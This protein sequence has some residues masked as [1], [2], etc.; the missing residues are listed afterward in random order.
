MFRSVS[1][2]IVI[3]VFTACSTSER[4]CSFNGFWEGPH[5]EDPNKKFYVQ[6]IDPDSSYAK[7]YWTDN[8][9][10]DS[11]F[12]IDSLMIVENSIH[13]FV[14]HWNCTYLGEGTESNIR[15]GFACE[16]EPFDSVMLVKNDG[17]ARYLTD[18]LPGCNEAG[19]KYHCQIP[20]QID[21]LLITSNVENNT[22]SLFI[23]SLLPEIINGECGRLNSFLLI[24]NNE[25]ICEEYFYGYTQNTLH[26]AESTT[27]S[28]TSI[29]VG[30]ALD[31]GFISGLNEPVAT[32]LEAPDFD[33]RIKMKHLLSMTSGLTPN[34]EKL[35]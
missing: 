12:Q 15:G 16:G 2:F 7:G 19:Y 24:K 29:L 13:F 25:L 23:Y 27:K 20:E 26:Q 30:I 5:P 22:D 8:G 10:Y 4:R 6:I 21:D 32:I 35:F 33:Q 1:L 31:N 28:I 14:P 34:D 17:A 18:A 11:G 3:V 9:F